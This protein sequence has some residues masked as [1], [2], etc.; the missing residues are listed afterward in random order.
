VML[1]WLRDRLND[2]L[3]RIMDALGYFDEEED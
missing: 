1:D 2:V 3:V